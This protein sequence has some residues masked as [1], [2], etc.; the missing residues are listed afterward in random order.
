MSPPSEGVVA[1]TVRILDKDYH[2]ACP[3]EERDD[4]LAAAQHL[5]TQMRHIRENSRVSGMERVAVIAALNIANELLRL[6]A[7]AVPA[8]DDSATGGDL[9]PRLR[10]LRE[11]IEATLDNGNGAGLA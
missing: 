8:G 6:R 11:R 3:P 4:L 10:G 1:V 5:N 7:T 9:L 2:V